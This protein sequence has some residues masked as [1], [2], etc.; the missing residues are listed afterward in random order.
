MKVRTH[1]IKLLSTALAGLFVLF[2]II[3]IW[4]ICF[5]GRPPAIHLKLPSPSIG[6]S[7]ELQL[8]V[9]DDRSGLR[10]IWIGIVRDRRERT[11]FEKEYPGKAIFTGGKIKK[12][13]LKVIIEP[14]KLDLPDG[15]AILRI[16]VRDFSWRKWWK[17]NSKYLE[18]EILIDTRAPDITVLTQVHNI[19]RGGS[20]LVIYRLSE[21]CPQSG[22]FVGGDFFPGHAGYFKNR[23]ILMAFCALNHTQGRGT[24]IFV[25]A[26]DYAQNSSRAGINYH[27]RKKKFRKDRL[28]LPESFLNRKVPEFDKELP[29]LTQGALI[30][31]FLAINR[32]VRKK[33]YERIMELTQKTTNTLFWKGVF[34]RQPKSARKA[35]FA[36][37]RDYLYKGKKVDSQV[38]LGIDLAS[39]PFSSVLASNSGKVVFGDNLGIYGKT[40][41]IDH[42][43]GLMSMYAHLSQVNVKPEQTVSHGEVVGRTGSTGLAGGDHLH[44][45]II[46]NKTF[47]NPIEWWDAKWIENNITSKIELIKQCCVEKEADAS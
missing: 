36:D 23:D 16:S 35:G 39:L 4:V 30:D 37:Y 5:E 46:V 3:A 41:I 33:N 2:G 19:T 10:K 12:D 28:R 1:N 31:R 17:G 13:T 22:V 7:Q 29:H 47:V 45:S 20:G 34:L 21:P 43:F 6:I 27:I 26:T 42:G 9:S 24:E 18:Q 8:T 44:F 38:H 25:K 32:D 40:V 14:K 11:I 15:K